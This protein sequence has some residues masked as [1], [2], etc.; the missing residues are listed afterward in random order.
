MKLYPNAKNANVQDLSFLRRKLIL[1]ANTKKAA[2]VQRNK[3]EH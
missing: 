3:H 1:L 2:L